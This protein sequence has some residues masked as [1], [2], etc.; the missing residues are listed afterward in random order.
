MGSITMCKK[1]CKKTSKKKG[2]TSTKVVVA[3]IIAI[4]L[5]WVSEFFLLY[6][7]N[8]G[9]PDVFIRSW[10][11]FWSV[12]LAALAGIK[13]TKVRSQAPYEGELPDEAFEDE[14]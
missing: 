2:H 6:T 9:Y 7:G 8:A 14:E 1:V 3:A 10:F 11:F 4:V 13:I 12:E 5:F